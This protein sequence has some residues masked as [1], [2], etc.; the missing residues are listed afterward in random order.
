MKSFIEFINEGKS[1]ELEGKTYSSG[2]GRYTCNGESISK[3]EYMKAS[4]AYKGLNT[5]PSSGGKSFNY[6]MGTAN[7]GSKKI[8]FYISTKNGFEKTTGKPVEFSN[9]SGY[10]F[11]IHKHENSASYAI[12]E[13]STGLMCGYGDGNTTSKALKSFVDYSV[14]SEKFLQ[15]KDGARRFN[16][17][18]QSALSKQKKNKQTKPE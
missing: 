9:L 6:R 18:V 8:E 1:F 11:A 12:T 4:E 13:L 7:L 3:E 5:K 15:D 10:K 2:F 16:E 14:F 17:M